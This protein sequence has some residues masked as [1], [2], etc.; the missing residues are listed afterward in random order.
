MVYLSK[1]FPLYLS[2]ETAIRLDSQ[3]ANQLVLC[4]FLA[5]CAVGGINRPG[6]SPHRREKSPKTHSTGFTRHNVRIIQKILHLRL[7]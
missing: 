6:D 7:Y 3:A 4:R 5:V 1:V 2:Y